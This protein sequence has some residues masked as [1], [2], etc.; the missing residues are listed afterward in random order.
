MD[1]YKTYILTKVPNRWT[2]FFIGVN[3]EINRCKTEK[4]ALTNV[5]PIMAWYN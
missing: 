1:T 4:L 5:N 3:R 2:T